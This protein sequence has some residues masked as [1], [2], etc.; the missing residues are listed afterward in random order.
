MI[1]FGA[2]PPKNPHH[3]TAHGSWWDSMTVPAETTETTETTET[4]H[5]L[6]GATCT[7][8]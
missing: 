8:A 1:G 6:N 5:T 4:R 7:V 2:N 3:R